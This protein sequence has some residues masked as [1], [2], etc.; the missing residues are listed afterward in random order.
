MAAELKAESMKR[1]GVSAEETEAELIRMMTRPDPKPDPIVTSAPIGRRE[2]PL[3]KE[4]H[5]ERQP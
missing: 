1:Y 3:N 4:K 5:D 2:K